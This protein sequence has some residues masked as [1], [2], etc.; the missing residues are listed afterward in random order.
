MPTLDSNYAA[1]LQDLVKKASLVDSE[2]EV[3][4]SDSHEYQLNPTISI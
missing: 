4:A 3:F 2:R 1:Y